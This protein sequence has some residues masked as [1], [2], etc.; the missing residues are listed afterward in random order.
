MYIPFLYDGTSIF[1]NIL[2]FSNILSV[3]LPIL[4]AV[5]F[6]TIIERKMLAAMQRRLGPTDV[7]LD[8]TINKDYC[9]FSIPS[10]IHLPFTY[11]SAKNKPC[12]WNRKR[13]FLVNKMANG[14]R[15]FN[16]GGLGYCSRNEEPATDII[17]VLYKDRIDN[18]L[19]SFNSLTGAK[20]KRFDSEVVDTLYNIT[21][22]E[23]KINF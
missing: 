20:W 1:I 22:T 13:L 23:D 12:L 3:I 6:M 14:I 17:N 15:F 16:S 11:D 7:G 19:I 18:P 9:K 21:S 4:L 10:I 2:N 5:A 8:Y